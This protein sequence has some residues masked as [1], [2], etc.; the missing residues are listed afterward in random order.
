MT[1]NFSS[2]VAEGFEYNSSKST[3][4]NMFEQYEAVIIQSLITSFGLDFLVADQHGGDVDTIHNVRKVGTDPEMRYKNQANADAYANRGDYNSTAYHSDSRY[5]SRNRECSTAK[6]AG[7][8][9]DAYTGEKIAPNGSYDLDHVISAKE[10]HDDRGRVL[11]ELDGKEL[12]N[13]SENLQPTNPHTNR[14]KKA[15]TMDEFLEKNGGE[16]SPAEQRRMKEADARARAA[17][18]AKLTRAYYLSPKFASDVATAA[19]S[20]GLKMGFRQ[21]VGL[22]MAE[23]WFALKEEFQYRKSKFN[24]GCSFKDYLIAIKEGIRNW[25]DRIKS[26]RQEL[27]ARFKDGAL[28]GVLSSITTTLINIFFTTAKN[29]VKIIRQVYSHLVE[30]AKILFFNP[31]RLPLGERVKAAMKIL[32]VGAGVVAG[33]LVNE[34]LAEV[35]I[36]PVLGDTVTAFLSALVSG[37]LSCTLLYFFDRSSIVAKLV[38][39]L[40][41]FSPY[42]DT[43]R[44]FEEQ[45]VAYDRYAAELA[46]IDM[47]LL[48]SETKRVQS[49]ADALDGAKD[50]YEL[51]DVLLA[52]YDR[53]GLRK[54]WGD[55]DPDDFFADRNNC[56]VFD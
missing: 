51:Y 24:A 28:A 47:A 35:T 32:A 41:S 19:G 29:A 3:F 52:I 26:K 15:K 53:Y 4:A 23:L 38:D 10:V 5:I 56:L 48:Q 18:E 25:F 42:A 16:Y 1:A 14:T 55:A 9:Q 2:N 44:Y 43:L 50:A 12:A 27:F 54:P 40:N 8:L 6:K 49:I 21:A 31:D 13:S 20:V 34:A 7:N 37:L 33:V 45:S 30:A 22:M 11:A 17:Y 39:F 36:I 46:K